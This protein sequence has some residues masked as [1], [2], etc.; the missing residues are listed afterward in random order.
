MQETSSEWVLGVQIQHF[1]NLYNAEIRENK[2]C[3]C[4]VQSREIPCGETIAAVINAQC[5]TVCLP[6]FVVHFQACPSIET[7]YI[8]KTINVSVEPTSVISSILFQIPFNQSQLE[9][10]NQVRILCNCITSNITY[11]LKRV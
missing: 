1:V 6:Y 3:C 9:M 8:A 4:D 2:Y 11:R 10:Y 7:C 5:P